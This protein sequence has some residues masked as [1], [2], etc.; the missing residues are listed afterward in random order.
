MAIHQFNT[1]LNENLEAQ[2]RIEY[3]AARYNSINAA[4]KRPALNVESLRGIV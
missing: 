4:K 2:A 1:A 3:N